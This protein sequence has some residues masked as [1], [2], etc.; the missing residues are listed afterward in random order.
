[1][2]AEPQK[3]HAW[4]QQMVG[5][6]TSETT[7]RM[8]PDQPLSVTQ[9]SE[10]VRSLGGLW[11]IGD[12][13][14]ECPDGTTMTSVMT[15]GFDPAKGRFVG[16]FVASMMSMIWH[17]E[18]RLEADG[19]TLTLETEGPSFAGDGS[20]A[21]YRDTVAIDDADHRTMTSAFQGEDGSW[22]EFMTARYRRKN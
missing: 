13:A 17:Y 7:C 9:G 22:T 12:G 6:W 2:K 4:L 16:T 8:G 18:G 11:T 3:E 21:K 5:D 20:T 15:L 1:M 14:G 10:S 19:R